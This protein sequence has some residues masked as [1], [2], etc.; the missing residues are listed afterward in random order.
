MIPRA[1]AALAACLFAPPAIADTWQNDSPGQLDRAFY[2]ARLNGA[3]LQLGCFRGSEGLRMTLVGGP[4][5]LPDVASVM[6]WIELPDGRTSRHPV[7]TE[8]IGGGENALLGTL[9]LGVE[10][11]LYFA[12]GAKLMIT[13]STGETLFASGMRGTSAAMHDFRRTCDL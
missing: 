6:L 4:V 1:F 9:L 13:D 3:M 10:G 8:H 7:E 12:L 2:S 5:H 11:R